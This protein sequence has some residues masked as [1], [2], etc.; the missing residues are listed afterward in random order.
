MKWYVKFE[1]ISKGILLK[2]LKGI[3]GIKC[4]KGIKRILTTYSRYSHVVL[5]W[6]IY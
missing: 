4:I 3:K 2:Y 1:S 6:Y 5:K